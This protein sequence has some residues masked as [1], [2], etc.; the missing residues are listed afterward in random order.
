MPLQIPQTVGAQHHTFIYSNKCSL[1]IGI[2]QRLSRD[3]TPPTLS[4][5]A[6]HLNH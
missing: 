2:Q 5:E 3:C 6:G 1:L 4:L